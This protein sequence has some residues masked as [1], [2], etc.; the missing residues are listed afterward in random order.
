MVA[1]AFVLRRAALSLVRSKIYMTLLL[2][3]VSIITTIKM[4]MKT[5]NKFASG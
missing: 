5:A 2:L 3:P 4:A 1:I